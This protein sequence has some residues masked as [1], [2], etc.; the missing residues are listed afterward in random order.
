MFSAGSWGHPAGAGCR[1]VVSTSPT[2]NVAQVI[3]RSRSKRHRSNGALAFSVQVHAVV[4]EDSKGGSLFLLVV[5]NLCEHR[6]EKQSMCTISADKHEE[7]ICG[8][9]K[10]FMFLGPE[11]MGAKSLGWQDN[12]G[13][14]E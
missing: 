13:D 11:V 2:V 3:G 8:P 6:I 4:H 1:P 10:P 12:V 14:N 9:T 7:R 5:Q